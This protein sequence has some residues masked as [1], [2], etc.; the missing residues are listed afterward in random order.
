MA[1]HNILTIILTLFSVSNH[2][3]ITTV[4]T[5][6][7]KELQLCR[8]I[9]RPLSRACFF[10]SRCVNTQEHDLHFAKVDGGNYNQSE[11]VSLQICELLSISTWATKHYFILQYA[12]CSCWL[13]LFKD[14]KSSLFSMSYHTCSICISLLSQPPQK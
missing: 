14:V 4:W 9:S 13:K 5:L 7:L 10:F 3:I 8:W 6:L 1:V 11:D 12:E 2:Q